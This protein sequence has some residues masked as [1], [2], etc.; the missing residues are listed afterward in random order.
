MTK[1]NLLTT[2]A[3]PDSE[4]RRALAK[5]YSLLIRL[6]EQ[7]ENKSNDEEL[8]GEKGAE[9]STSIQTTPLTNDVDSVS[10]QHDIPP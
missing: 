2:K 4:K 8:I 3:D 5:V 9:E 10:P 1:D 7:A 6:A